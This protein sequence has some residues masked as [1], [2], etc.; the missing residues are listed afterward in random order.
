MLLCLLKGES[1][2]RFDHELNLW[3]CAGLMYETRRIA[4]RGLVD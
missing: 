4:N 2:E 1:F 3:Y